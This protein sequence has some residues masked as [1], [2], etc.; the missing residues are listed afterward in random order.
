M[1][2]RQRACGSRLPT[3]MRLTSTHYLRIVRDV[4]PLHAVLWGRSHTKYS[5]PKLSGSETKILPR[6]TLGGFVQVAWVWVW[7]CVCVL[8]RSSCPVLTCRAT[9]QT[10][11]T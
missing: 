9:L 2:G 1:L 5:T 8:S 6:L 3:P 7:V 10:T 4:H 11:E